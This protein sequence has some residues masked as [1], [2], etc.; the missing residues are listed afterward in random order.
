MGEWYEVKSGT[1]I[2]GSTKDEVGRVGASVKDETKRFTEQWDDKVINIR[3]RFRDSRRERKAA[4][5]A[6]KE[7]SALR[8][9]SLEEERV[10]QA[11]QFN[12]L[13]AQKAGARRK[14]M[15]EGMVGEAVGMISSAPVDGPNMEVNKIPMLDDVDSMGNSIPEV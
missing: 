9:R 15:A 12:L 5:A 4:E 8:R 11:K 14:E 2:G 1:G 6:A 13:E 3:S 7:L 10:R